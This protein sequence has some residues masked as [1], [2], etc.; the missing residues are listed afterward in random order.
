[1]EYY[2]AVKHVR[3][4]KFEGKDQEA[5]D[6]LLEEINN[7]P[8]LSDIDNMSWEIGVLLGDYTQSKKENKK[9]IYTKAIQY[10]VKNKYGIVYYIDDFIGCVD[11]GGF[12]DYDGIGYALDIDGKEI[13]KIHCDTKYLKSLKRKGAIFIAWY[14]R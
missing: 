7:R 9:E 11:C 4:M 8:A 13:E 14:N 12:I 10:T 2:E 6:I 5:I 3:N 1:M